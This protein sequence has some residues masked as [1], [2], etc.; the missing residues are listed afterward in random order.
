[1]LKLYFFMKYYF[2]LGTN[3]ALSI[4]EILA[5][6][7]MQNCEYLRSGVLVLDLAEEID[8]VET[9]K[10]LGGSIKLG[11]VRK[12]MGVGR[13]E[14]EVISEIK[15]LFPANKDKEVGK[16]PFG[17]SVYGK[18]KIDE[19]KLGMEIKTHLKENGINARWVT[20]REKQLSSVV[21]E[22]NKLIS[23]GMEIVIIE[24]GDK[25]YFGKTLAVQPF[26]ELSKRDYGRPGRDDHSGMLPPKL[27]MIMLNLGNTKNRDSVILDPFCGSGTILTEAALMGYDNLVGC[28]IS[29][30]AI[31]DSKVNIEWIKEKYKTTDNRQQGKFI[32]YTLHR[33][34]VRHLSRYVR[35]A[36]VD[37]IITEPFL[38]PQRGK[39]D[40]NKTIKELEG[41]YA[42]AIEEFEKVLKPGGRV[43]MVWPV[44][45][46]GASA[47]LNP[48]LGRFKIAAPLA[49]DLAYKLRITARNTI[50]YG[51]PGQKVWREIVILEKS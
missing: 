8:A 14:D 18:V 11:V 29:A 2:I 49:D 44:F 28:D 35:P 37:T 27:A 30:K 25:I 42:F 26:R 22:T 17:I 6:F 45:T 1:M 12:E 24:A 4:A 31:E 50:I 38:G 15:K 40:H 10:R 32:N 34:D 21:V 43:V 33:T 13:Q 7:G 41:L 39:V 20:S 48:A 16:F 5:C 36:S 46:S 51:R 23:R 19:K 9:M 3:H 47:S